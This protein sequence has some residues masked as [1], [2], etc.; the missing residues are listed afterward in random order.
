MYRQP[1]KPKEMSKEVNE[2][3]WF[4]ENNDYQI[5][6]EA[7]LDFHH[8]A[9]EKFLKG[10]EEHNQCGKKGLARMKTEDLI[11]AVQE[12]VIDLWFY[13]NELKRRNL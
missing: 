4:N 7:L 1:I 3:K 10:I 13:T 11:N 9:R 6:D 12:E 8:S 2:G 5:M